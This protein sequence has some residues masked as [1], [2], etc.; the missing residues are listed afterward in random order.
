MLWVCVFLFS[1][2]Y[3][4]YHI[5]SEIFILLNEVQISQYAKGQFTKF[6]KTRQLNRLKVYCVDCGK[7]VA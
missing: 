1:P 5:T 3:I 7:I 6:F 2:S 4:L